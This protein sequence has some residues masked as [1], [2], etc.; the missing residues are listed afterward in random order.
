MPL[1]QIW[2]RLLSRYSGDGSDSC[3]PRP[4]RHVTA[5]QGT[6]AILRPDRRLRRSPHYT[7]LRRSSIG[8]TRRVTCL[9]RVSVRTIDYVIADNLL[10]LLKPMERCTFQDLPM[11]GIAPSIRSSRSVSPSLSI[12][13]Q[14]IAQ[15]IRV[16][17]FAWIFFRQ[18]RSVSVR[19]LAIASIIA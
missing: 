19:Q 14:R 7:R 1:V 18:F 10:R 17:H 8:T 16:A 4:V 3:T 12:T 5:A 15:V 6:F 11:K 13:G 2:S 9:Q